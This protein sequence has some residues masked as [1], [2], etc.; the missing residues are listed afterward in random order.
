MIATILSTLFRML[1]RTGF[2]SI[3]QKIAKGSKRRDQLGVFF[4]SIAPFCS[5]RWQKRHARD[6][7]I[8]KTALICRRS[9]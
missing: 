3:E 1:V 2:S 9:I 7:L 4:V 8:L 6:H 5:S